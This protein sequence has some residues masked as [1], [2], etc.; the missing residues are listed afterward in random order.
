MTET[1]QRIDRIVVRHLGVNPEQVDENAALLDDLDA[2]SL[3]VIE[4]VMAFE[5]EFSIEIHDAEA[6]KLSTV[7]DCYRLVGS[8]LA[9]PG[10]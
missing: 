8:K 4:L 7:G 5:D 10:A 2:D 6:E 3:D 9:A 1:E